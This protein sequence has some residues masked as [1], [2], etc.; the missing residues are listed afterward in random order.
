MTVGRLGAE[1]MVLSGRIVSTG[2]VCEGFPH[3]QLDVQAEELFRGAPLLNKQG[4]VLGLMVRPRRSRGT[5]DRNSHS[6][7]PGLALPSTA[8]EGGLMS[9][10]GTP[11]EVMELGPEY[12]C[13]RCDTVF[14]P[15]MDR[16][17]DC[18]TLLPHR[19]LRD[20]HTHAVKEPPLKGL[21]AAKAALASMGIPANRA[22]V[23]PRTW[24]FSPGFQGQD[25][26]T[27]VDLT[28]DAAGDNLI[29]RGPVVRLPT[30]GFEHF[31][32]HLLTLN[33]ETSG[34]YR[35]GTA[36]GTVYLSL[37][38]PV[39]SVDASTFPSTVSE[40]SRALAHYRA[41]FERHFA[42]EPAFEHEQD[43]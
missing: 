19:W 5:G 39:V 30:D 43:S 24:R 4:G 20:V 7:L 8:F 16:C 11:E 40:F 35:F 12:G 17:L 32:R 15:E 25:E 33:D 26:Q 6:W 37:C 14:E 1:P 23:G 41:A 21:F 28:T 36:E 9:A 31:Y 18:G 27:Q 3:L 13:P 10:E 29:L 38:E 34:P 42:L 22:R 2:R